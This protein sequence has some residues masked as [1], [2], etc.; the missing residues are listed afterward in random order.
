MGAL[1]ASI[2]VAGATEPQALQAVPSYVNPITL[3]IEDP[4]NNPGLGQG[5]T[6]ELILKTPASL[7]IDAEGSVFITFR[8]GLVK[9]SQDFRLELLDT[10]GKATKAIPYNIVAE[11]PD[12]NTQ[13]IQIKVPD[14]NA[15]LRVS[16]VSIPMG[17][18]VVGFVA[19][20]P[21]GEAIAVPLAEQDVDDSAI[22]I[23]ENTNSDEVTGIADEDRGQLLT[24]LGVAAGILLVI[25][26]AAGVAYLRKK[27]MTESA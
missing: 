25:G 11:Q 9:E 27:K 22:S 24:F 8:V 14:Q 17:R 2:G 7:L 19:F 5:M 13:D 12:E 16:L 4:G 10:Q 15:V 3:E 1:L 18:E 6:E 23:Y 20:A 26:V 21:E